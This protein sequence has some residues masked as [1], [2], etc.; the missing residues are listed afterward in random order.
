MKKIISYIKEAYS[1]LVHKV[2]WP[3]RQELSSSTVIVMTASLIMAVVVFVID[4]SFE[5]VVSH[6]YSMIFK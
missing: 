1:E 2:S 6:F 5:W 3:T 4:F